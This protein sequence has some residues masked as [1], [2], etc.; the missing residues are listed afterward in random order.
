MAKGHRRHLKAVAAYIERLEREG[1]HSK[2]ESIRKAKCIRQLSKCI[3]DPT[4][5]EKL[6]SERLQINQQALQRSWRHLRQSSINQ[7]VSTNQPVPPVPT[8]DTVNLFEP[9]VS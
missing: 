2:V 7:P 8:I 9:A 1:N 6:E 3:D 5:L 4:I